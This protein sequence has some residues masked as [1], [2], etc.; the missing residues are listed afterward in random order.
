MKTLPENSTMEERIKT[1][2]R[3]TRTCPHKHPVETTTQPRIKIS[4][5]TVSNKEL[6]LKKVQKRRES[7]YNAPAAMPHRQQVLD[8]TNGARLDSEP[9]SPNQNLT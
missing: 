2:N 7:T 5:A 3:S 8:L 1:R 4:E 6:E 9:N